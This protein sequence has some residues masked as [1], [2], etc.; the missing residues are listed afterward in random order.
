MT[1]NPYLPLAVKILNVKQET[2]LDKLYRVEYNIKPSYGQFFQLSLPCIGEG[3]ISV[4]DFGD[5][6]LEF[7]VRKAGCLT[8]E[9][10]KLDVG[11]TLYLRGPYGT[12]FNTDDFRNKHLVI[13]A[14]GSGVAPVRS[15]INHYAEHPDKITKIDLVLG[16]KNAS[17]IIFR[18]EIEI[19]EEK[20]DTVVTVDETCDLWTGKCTGLVTKYIKNIE[21]SEF[22]NMEIVI[23]GPPIMM[24]FAVAEFLAM[25]VPEENIIVSY[26][27]RMSC[28]LGKCGHCKIDD[29]YVCVDGPVMRY[30]KAVQLID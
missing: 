21:L 17:S 6:W 13:V 24:K 22:A 18:E 14:G 27:R 7:L 5:G 4:S 26:E 15:L 29:T 23:V 2:E 8:E 1:D 11:D 25:G 19:W 3:P 16:F 10:H 30:D 28:G 9:I 20:F 12:G